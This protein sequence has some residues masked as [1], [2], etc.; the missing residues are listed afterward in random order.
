M[1][2]PFQQP[3][4]PD[5]FNAVGKT[6]GHCLKVSI[7][8]WI[9]HN[10]QVTMIQKVEES[11]SKP[12]L[13]PNSKRVYLNGQIHDL[14]VPMREIKLSD[15]RLPDGK[16]QKNESVR[17]YDTSGP[18]GDP[19]F[20]GNVELGLPKLR[21]DWISSRKD[22]E[23]IVGREIIP[24]DNGYLSARHDQR[25]RDRSQELP[26]F[27][28]SNISVL[29]GK[30]GNPVTQLHYARQG[31]ITPEMEFVSVRENM[32]LQVLAEKLNTSAEELG[33]SLRHQHNGHSVG[34]SI[35]QEITP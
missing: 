19:D 34:A 18:W 12:S 7:R 29:R 13:F 6:S 25:S 28:R 15:T 23:E 22:V 8:P 2:L 17:V 14:K 26:D 35:P 9:I 33:N 1:D 16:E 5:A 11:E 30:H 3:F 31:I 24:A 10:Y 32:K 20:H 21:Q 27:D 4:E